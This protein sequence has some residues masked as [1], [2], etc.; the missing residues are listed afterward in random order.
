[1]NKTLRA[2]G[3]VSGATVTAVGALL[4]SA[5]AAAGPLPG[6]VVRSDLGGGTTMTARLVDQF[7]AYQR[8][9]VAGT[10]TSRQV[11][12]SGKIRVAITGAAKGGVIKGGYVVGCQINLS[13][14]SNSGTGK[15]DQQGTMS[16]PSVGSTLSLGAGQAAYVPIIDQT[17][18]ALDTT[19]VL[20]KISGY[21]FSGN[22]GSVAYSQEPLRVNGCAGYAQARARMTIQ[23]TTSNAK[24]ETTLWGRPFSLG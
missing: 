8:G 16:L 21:Q 2:T 23:V 20:Y 17:N 5:N 18:S 6:N 14:M 10:P 15:V 12:L 7:V 19:N 24:S 4:L 1:M 9:N 3:V 13:G 11:L 22:R